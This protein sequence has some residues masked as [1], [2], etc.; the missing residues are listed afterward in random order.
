[1]G[2]LAS[3]LIHGLKNPLSGLQSFVRSRQEN[4][5]DHAPEEL[6]EAAA[7]AQRMQSLVGEVARILEEQQ[8]VTSYEISLSELVEVIAARLSPQAR[9]AGVNFK[10]QVNT[11]AVFPNR[12]ANLIL[13][14]LENLLQ[15][16]IQA[17]PSGG[18]VRLQALSDDGEIRLEVQDEGPG[19]APGMEA[20]LFRPCRSTKEGG[21]GIGLALSQQLAKTI[22][23][24]LCLKQNSARGCI[25]ELLVPP[26]TMSED[27]A[28][29]HTLPHPSQTAVT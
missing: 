23:A 8:A 17:T 9:A 14:I 4:G 15:N 5:N 28:R 18:A 6:T 20:N 12:K 10:S 16:A 2:A 3:H 26:A 7:T 13:L 11:D 21:S 27:S 25:F 24:T 1:M 22:G 19:L 29:S